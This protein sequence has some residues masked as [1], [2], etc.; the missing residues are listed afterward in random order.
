[1]VRE[2]A[3]VAVVR[4]PRWVLAAAV[5]S[6]LVLRCYDLSRQPADP[7]FACRHQRPPDSVIHRLTG[8]ADDLGIRFVQTVP[9]DRVVASQVPRVADEI[10]YARTAFR[11]VADEFLDR[12]SHLSGVV[13]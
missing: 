8:N 2:P 11:C 5:N 1:M 12:R 7:I 13:R 4:L 3:A 6:K 9:P 10:L